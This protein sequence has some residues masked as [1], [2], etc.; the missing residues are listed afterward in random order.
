MA[1]NAVTYTREQRNHATT[2]QMPLITIDYDDRHVVYETTKSG[3]VTFQGSPDSPS[4]ATA[5]R[6]LR[7]LLQTHCPTSPALAELASPPAEPVPAPAAA[8]PPAA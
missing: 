3:R 8:T 5:L 2:T 6:L 4:L 1:N 7:E